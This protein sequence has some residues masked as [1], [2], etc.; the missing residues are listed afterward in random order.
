LGNYAEAK[1][2]LA[3]LDISPEQQQRFAARIEELEA[4]AVAERKC[5]PSSR[6]RR[7]RPRKT[8]AIAKRSPQSGI[9]WPQMEQR[10]DN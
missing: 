1:T 8:E 6:R 7:G 2:T 10:Y 9:A 5:E 4:A 3:T